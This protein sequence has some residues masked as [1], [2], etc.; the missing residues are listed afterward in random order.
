M[1]HQIPGLQAEVCNPKGEGPHRDRR[2]S[3][4]SCRPS[5]CLPTCRPPEPLGRTMC[6][7]ACSP[8][9]PSSSQHCADRPGVCPRRTVWRPSARRCG[10]AS[11]DRA[12]TL[13]LQ[14]TRQLAPPR[15][16][17]CGQ[18]AE[19]PPFPRPPG[20]PPSRLLRRPLVNDVGE[21][22]GDRLRHRP[23][24]CDDRPA[25]RRGGRSISLAAYSQRTI[26]HASHG[27]YGILVDPAD[28]P[29][30]QRRDGQARW[31]PSSNPKQE[32]SGDLKLWA[33]RSSLGTN[34]R[35][36]R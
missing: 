13:T 32:V 24:G 5:G 27:R 15:V 26:Y 16:K 7:N 33:V 1:I 9:C 19:E 17:G 35:D 12:W 20:H 3:M 30:H 22:N 2:R 23:A 10:G 29:A 14:K 21:A 34:G 28:G 31:T 11:D 6:R 4:S 18:L 36:G 25:E 8:S